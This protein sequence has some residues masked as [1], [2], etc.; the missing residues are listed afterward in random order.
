VS[1][2]KNA[3]IQATHARDLAGA[4]ARALD[5]A[6]CED[7]VALDVRGLSQITDYIVIGSG[8]SD[9]QLRTAAQK[10]E[11]AAKALGEKPFRHAV[12]M[13]AT[14]VVI[15]FVNV[16]AHIFEP[17]ARAHYDLEMLWG[18]ADR[19]DW[20]GDGPPTAADPA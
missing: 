15:D 16:V 6:K 19:I 12:D 18:D 7:I 4:I 8:T 9:R 2:R 11:D 13:N 14:W 20:R 17:A 1:E 10:A 3:E 5:D